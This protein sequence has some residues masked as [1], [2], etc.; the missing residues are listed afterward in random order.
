MQFMVMNCL[1]IVI[2]LIA[3]GLIMMMTAIQIGVGVKDIS[4]R[5]VILNHVNLM[6]MVGI[7]RTLGR[8]T[9]VDHHVQHL[10]VILVE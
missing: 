9:I 3:D 4:T 8:G 5:R 10:K 1:K 7:R 6:V 2:V